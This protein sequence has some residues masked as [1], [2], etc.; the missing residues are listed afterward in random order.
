MFAIISFF[1]M[2]V[3]FGAESAPVLTYEAAL[4]EAIESNAELRRAS[5]TL[6]TARADVL[7][8]KAIFD[9]SLN[10]SGSYSWDRNK[11]FFQ[12]IPYDIKN[13]MSSGSLGIGGALASGTS[14]DLSTAY[15]RNYGE[16]ANLLAGDNPEFGTFV[17]DEFRAS[18][19]GSV[20]QQLLKGHRFAYNMQPLNMARQGLAISELG[21]EQTRQSVLST[22]AQAYWNWV[23]QFQLLELRRRAVIVSTEALRIGKLKAESGDLAPIEVTRLAAALIQDQSTE[24]ETENAVYQAKNALLL[25]M[26]QP[27]GREIHPGQTEVNVAQLELDVQTAVDAAMQQNLE[28]LIQRA[29]VENAQLSLKMS[30]HALLPSLSATFSA[31]LGSQ[32][33]SV[34]KAFAGLFQD[35]RFPNLS[36]GGQFSMPIGNRAARGDRRKSEAALGTQRVSLLELEQNIAV[37]V[38]QQ[39]QVLN[40]ARKRVELADIN[41]QLA[42]QTLVAEEASAELGR[43]IQKDVLESRNN[44]DSAR[45]EAVKSRTDYQLAIVELQ[46][47]QGQLSVPGGP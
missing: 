4:L 38:A 21:F 43:A 10:L 3:S 47:L 6:D 24:I 16:Y 19:N 32:N 20:T 12:G 22:T 13:R 11:S 37:Q 40:S 33:T 26:G 27:P 9:P 39:V 5:Y 36:V 17:Q 42:E 7:A 30:K 46:R 28:L 44:L 18:L 31:G 29:N 41:V 15:F 23:Y 8:S 45:V 34:G 1:F 2:S 35:E 25:A 14:Y